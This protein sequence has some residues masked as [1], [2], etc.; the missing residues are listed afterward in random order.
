LNNSA[1]DVAGKKRSHDGAS[2]MR[3]PTRLLRKLEKQVVENGPDTPFA[4]MNGLNSFSD[5][6]KLQFCHN[7]EHVLFALEVVE[8]SSLADVCGLSNVLNRDVLKSTIRKKLKRSS[9]QT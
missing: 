5:V 4:G 1:N 2:Q 9:K 7:A 8:E 6:T 3:A